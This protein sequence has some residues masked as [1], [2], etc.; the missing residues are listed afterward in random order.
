MIAT[1]H[2]GAVLTGFGNLD[3]WSPRLMD[4]VPLGTTLRTE[5]TAD[6]DIFSI[7]RQPRR[8]GRM[9]LAA[10]SAGGLSC[11]AGTAVVRANRRIGRAEKLQA[12]ADR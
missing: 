4:R 8:F 7:G 12:T 2:A 5:N 10:L 6:T 11:P 9:T 1:K 3:R